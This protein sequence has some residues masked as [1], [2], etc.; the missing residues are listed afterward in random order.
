MVHAEEILKRMY[1][2]NYTLKVKT[3]KESFE[4]MIEKYEQYKL[5]GKVHLTEAKLLKA[6]IDA[7]EKR[8]KVLS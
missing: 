4:F 3:K 5:E 7:V 1:A 2:V 6:T 8:E